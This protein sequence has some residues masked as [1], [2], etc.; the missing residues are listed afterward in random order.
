MADSACEI[1]NAVL[2]QLQSDLDS[3][4]DA[5]RGLR[6]EVE[7]R[8]SKTEHQLQTLESSPDDDI[9]L[10]HAL[11]AAGLTAIALAHT[12]DVVRLDKL[13]QDHGIGKD[14]E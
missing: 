4:H 8:V 6:G 9:G 3:L 14:G 1:T 12:A 7:A 10:G 5:I 11:K 2:L 13:M